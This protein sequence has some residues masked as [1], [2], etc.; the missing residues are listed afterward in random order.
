MGGLR[1]G[2]VLCCHGLARLACVGTVFPNT[3]WNRLLAVKAS[4]KYI[5]VK[6][7]DSLITRATNF[8]TQKL[9]F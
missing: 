3:I 7:V 4:P 1:V 8:L 9:K 2:A 6:T 5:Y